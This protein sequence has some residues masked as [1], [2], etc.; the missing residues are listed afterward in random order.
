M[1]D[2]EQPLS[3][4]PMDE[5]FKGLAQSIGRAVL[6][7]TLLEK[8]LLVDIAGRKATKDGVSPKLAPWLERLEHRTAGQL[9]KVLRDE[10]DLDEEVAER[11]ADVIDRRNWLVHHFMQDPAVMALQAESADYEGVIARVDQISQD[12]QNVINEIGPAAFQGAERVSGISMVK[13]V[14]EVQTLDLEAVDDPALRRLLEQLRLID[15]VA[16]A[17]LF[18]SRP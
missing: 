16:L 2:G 15:P 17:E 12:I 3:L 18:G 1:S 4:E 9:L 5:E 6:A 7:G 10:L 13:L 11:V 8:I 14:Q